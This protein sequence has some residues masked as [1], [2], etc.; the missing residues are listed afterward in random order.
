[1]DFVYEVG[2]RLDEKRRY[3][4][5]VCEEKKGDGDYVSCA[6]GKMR[7]FLLAVSTLSLSLFFFRPGGGG[8]C[9]ECERER[10]T[11]HCMSLRYLTTVVSVLSFFFPAWFRVVWAFFCLRVVSGHGCTGPPPWRFRRSLKLLPDCCESFEF[12]GCY[13]TG[14]LS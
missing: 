14:G 11:A 1:M 3:L 7:S 4:L 2:L 5:R 10:E 9:N 8:C 6:S 13:R 12:R